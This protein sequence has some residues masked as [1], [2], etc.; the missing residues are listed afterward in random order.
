MNRLAKA[1]A[2]GWIAGITAVAWAIVAALGLGAHAAVSAGFIP[3]RL[4][5]GVEGAGFLPALLTPLSSALVHANLLHL[6]LNLMLLLIC[7]APVER[8]TGRVGLL[9]LYVVGA[10]AAAAAHWVVDPMSQVPVV[11]ASGAISAVVGGY[12]LLFGQ[13]RVQVANPQLAKALHVLW[14]AAAWIG[15]QLL[16]GYATQTSAGPS[17]AIVAH[18]GGF[19]AGLLL[20]KPLLRLHWRKA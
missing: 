5:Q 16:L 7:G 8:A 11:G 13:N 2:T 9:V 18:I 6:G 17:I 20:I 14:L 15:L 10:V 1:S 12:A 19:L 3:V 4:T